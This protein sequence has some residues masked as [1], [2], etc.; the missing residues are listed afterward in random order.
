MLLII[1]NKRNNLFF[2]YICS[3]IVVKVVWVYIVGLLENLVFMI[4]IFYVVVEI[5]FWKKMVMFFEEW[6]GL[7]FYYFNVDC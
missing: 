3:V 2:I 6:L 5:K 4:V 7:D 1:W